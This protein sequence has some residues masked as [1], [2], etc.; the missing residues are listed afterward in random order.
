[1]SNRTTNVNIDWSLE[2][3]LDVQMVVLANP[4]A[5]I[6]VVMATSNSYTDM[7]DAIN[8]ANNQPETQIIS[9]SWG[10]DE[11]S[12]QSNYEKYFSRKNICY[13][14]SSGDNGIVEYPSSSPNVLSVGGTSL[15]IDANSIRISETTWYNNLL[16][17]GGCGYSKYMLSPSYQKNN[18]LNPNNYRCTP[19]ISLCADPNNGVFVVNQNNWYVFGGTSVS[20]PLMA[21]ILSLANQNRL[22]NSKP[23][24]STVGT[25]Y[26]L[27]NFLYEN[28]YK[29]N[30]TYPYNNNFYDIQNGIDGI[31][32]ANNGYDVPTG[33]GVPYC[34]TLVNSLFNL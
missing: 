25:T 17:A 4:Y 15:S 5:Q 3:S 16:S 32:K 27:Q 7:Y 23:T 13:I 10:G 33:L 6:T 28:I 21:G 34:N 29:K 26:P 2:L 22:N 19:D 11:F 14:A 20:A 31:Y 18:L 9:M 24:L 30:Q 8:W 1:M 12:G